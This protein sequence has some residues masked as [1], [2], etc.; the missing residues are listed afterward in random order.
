MKKLFLSIAIITFCFL[1]SCNQPSSNSDTNSA[2]T[3]QAE[4]DKAGTMAVYKAIETGD[5]SGLD[6]V[7]DKDAIDHSGG[8]NGAEIKG[9]D[10][11]KAMFT[12]MHDN[13]SDLKIE[14]IANAT[15]GDYNFDLNHMTGTTKNAFMGMPANTKIDMMSV[16]VVKIKDGKAVEHWGYQDPNEM[17]KMMQMQKGMSMDKM[18]TSKMHK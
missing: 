18:D 5:V 9:L 8:P 10:S 11:I 17:M 6:S 14:S 13:M 7:I 12:Q 4:K 3:S 16:D 1:I 2:A 15:D